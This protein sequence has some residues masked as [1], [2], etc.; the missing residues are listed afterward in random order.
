MSR[1]DDLRMV[2]WDPDLHRFHKEHGRWNKWIASPEYGRAFR[3]YWKK[4]TVPRNLS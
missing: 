2:N 4:G 3:A 1:E